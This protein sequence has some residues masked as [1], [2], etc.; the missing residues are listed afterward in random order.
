M[1]N[2]ALV[3]LMVAAPAVAQSEADR[4]REQR[5]AE[6]QMRQAEEQMRQA[7]RQL[8]DAARKLARMSVDLGKLKDIEKRV[9]IFGDHARLGIVMRSGADPKTDAV[10]AYVE[11][12]SPGGPAEDA[13]L[14]AGDVITTF[15]GQPLAG[16]STESHGD[17]CGPCNKLTQLAAKL[18]DGDKV[19]LGYRRGSGNGTVTIVARRLLGPN[20]K[21]LGVPGA[22]HIEIPEIAM[23]DIDVD[24]SAGGRAWRDID[25]VAMNPELGAYFG[26]SEGL[27]VVQ[28]PK[29]NPLK[30]AGGD[31]ILEIGD[32]TPASPTQA[33]RILGSYDPGDTVTLQVIRK[34]EKLTLTSQVPERRSRTFHWRGNAPEAPA[35]PAPPAPPTPPSS[36]PE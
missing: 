4:E 3:L 1:I 12:L 36:T 15:D 33:M 16:A 24:V 34:H 5:E 31:V 8:R 29:D 17:E 22:E 32:R 11:A 2:G 13:G 18:K 27:L 14:R 30:L 9:V 19:V 25:M 10:G 35:P 6:A 20:I 23:P 21:I 26:T 28:A 7:E